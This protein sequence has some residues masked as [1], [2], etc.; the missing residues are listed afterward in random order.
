MKMKSF[1][2]IVSLFTLITAQAATVSAKALLGIESRIENQKEAL[3]D[4]LN[5]FY[6]DDVIEG[7]I[8]AVMTNTIE[9]KLAQAEEMLNSIDTD[10]QLTEEKIAEIS[11]LLD[12]VERL[13]QE[14]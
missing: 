14:I 8:V 5:S 7:K 10:E 12:E 4:K 2:A 9:D 6:T 3:N 11:A 1:I 13:I